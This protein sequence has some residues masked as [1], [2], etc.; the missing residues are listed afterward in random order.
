MGNIAGVCFGCEFPCSECSTGPK[1]CL[2][3]DQKFGDAYLYGPGCIDSCPA[4]YSVNE[5]EKKCEGCGSGCDVCDENDQRICLQCESG[6][7]LHL[8]ACVSDC[9][10]GY[11]SNYEASSC[12]PLSDLDIRLIPFPCLIIAAVFLFLSY[13]GDK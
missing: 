7:M 8:D 2:A 6:L 11:L 13:V 1:I 10:K 4:G 3:C 9:P 5:A 12:Y